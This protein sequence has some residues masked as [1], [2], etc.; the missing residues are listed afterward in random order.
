[1]SNKNQLPLGNPDTFIGETEEMDMSSL[2]EHIYVIAVAT[3]DPK[4]CKYVPE[5]I[6][7]PFGFYEMVEQVSMMWEM[8]QH[9]AK[10]IILSKNVNTRPKFLDEC[11]I[12]YIEAKASSIVAEGMLNGEP[13]IK[14]FTCRAGLLQVE[15]TK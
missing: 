11:T 3:G 8:H 9:H 5:T 13:L 6:H 14:D 4:K 2:L 10:V 12:D 15:E 1:M 7:G